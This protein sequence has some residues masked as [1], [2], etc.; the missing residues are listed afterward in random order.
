MIQN[1]TM[2][3]QNF[4]IILA[5]QTSL[6]KFLLTASRMPSG[7][8]YIYVLGLGNI[9]PFLDLDV[10]TTIDT[11]GDKQFFRIL[12]IGDILIL[13]DISQPMLLA[14][15]S[16]A[17]ANL[18]MVKPVESQEPERACCVLRNFN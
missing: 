3:E 5:A 16:D 13:G 7:H 12:E 1:R 14:I 2:Y 18:K 6:L 17:A 4:E 15:H 9:E 11:Y 8:A 10:N